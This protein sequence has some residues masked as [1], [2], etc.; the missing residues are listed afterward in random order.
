MDALL[1]RSQYHNNN[2][3]YNSQ[4]GIKLQHLDG[5]GE[6]FM[7]LWKFLFLFSFLCSFFISLS[8]LDTIH[9]GKFFLWMAVRQICTYNLNCT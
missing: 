5:T 3:N 9:I 7:L 8:Y 1:S 4:A 6:C 2:N